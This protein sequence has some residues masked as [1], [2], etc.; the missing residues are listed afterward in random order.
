[1]RPSQSY[2]R[3]LVAW[4]HFPDDQTLRLQIGAGEDSIIYLP[5]GLDRVDWERQEEE[6]KFGLPEKSLFSDQAQPKICCLLNIG[7][8][9]IKVSLDSDRYTDCSA[10]NL[11]NCFHVFVRQ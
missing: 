5:S 7:N 1:M 9:M 3:R 8:G 2:K 11:I 10:E 4:Q 6:E